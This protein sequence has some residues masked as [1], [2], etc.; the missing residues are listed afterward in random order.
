[1]LSGTTQLR[2]PHSAIVVAFARNNVESNVIASARINVAPLKTW[3]FCTRS[4]HTVGV[5][6]CVCL[7]C[8]L[9]PRNWV[10]AHILKAGA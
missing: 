2:T 4:K 6:V 10:P 1:M 3:G 9:R 7:G 8:F 5:R